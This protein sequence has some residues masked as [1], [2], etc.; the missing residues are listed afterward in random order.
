MPNLYIVQDT[1]NKAEKDIFRDM[2][3]LI[4]YRH[5]CLNYLNGM[6]YSKQHKK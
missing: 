5:M 6:Y 1:N 3:K 4:D 2:G